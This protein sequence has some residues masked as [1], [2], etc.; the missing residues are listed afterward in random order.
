MDG[1]RSKGRKVL[2]AAVKGLLAAGEAAWWIKGPATFIVELS[3][4]LGALEEKHKEALAAATTGELREVLTQAELATQNAVLA[5]A[6]GERI[7]EVLATIQGVIEVRLGDV[8]RA[9][10]TID[11]RRAEVQERLSRLETS[12][13]FVAGEASTATRYSTDSELRRVAG[14]LVGLL[15]E[16]SIRF[17]AGTLDDE[18]ERTRRLAEATAA[19]AD[20]RYDEALTQVSDEMAEAARRATDAARGSYE[21]LR[22]REIGILTV[23]ALAH[24]GFRDWGSAAACFERIVEVAPNSWRARVDLATCMTGMGRPRKASRLFRRAIGELEILI[25]EEGR[26]ELLRDLAVTLCN[27]CNTLREL[28]MAEHSLRDSNRA[29]ELLEHLVRNDKQNGPVDD[30]A[31]SLSDRGLTL[32]DLGKPNDAIADYDRAL[33]LVRARVHGKNQAERSEDLAMVLNNRGMTLGALH[34]FDEAVE[35]LTECIEIRSHLLEEEGFEYVAGLLASA[36]VNRG[37]AFLLM[38]K[39]IEAVSEYGRAIEIYARLVEQEGCGELVLDFTKALCNRAKVAGKLLKFD[40][41]I[42]DLDRAVENLDRMLLR[43]GRVELTDMLIDAL[44]FRAWLHRQQQKRMLFWCDG[45]SADIVSL[46]VRAQRP[47]GAAPH[48]GTSAT[49]GAERSLPA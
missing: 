38:E 25:N 15:A 12:V 21:R 41:A 8:A 3:G 36:F 28:G 44:R 7:E 37:T 13:T 10:E 27:S 47:E 45:I 34:R 42:N 33:A 22:N 9:I 31:R 19:N 26:S 11:A 6:A 2:E 40:A 35:D 24:H 48:R 23:R 32:R 1:S 20:R 29:V 16:F 39:A 17:P 4:R 46:A 14:Q 18:E 49:A 30:L 43:D 5:A